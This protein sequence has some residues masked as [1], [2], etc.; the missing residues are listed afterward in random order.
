MDKNLTV[1][2]LGDDG[3]AKVFHT[4]YKLSGLLGM[5]ISDRSFYTFNWEEKEE[6]SSTNIS[7]SEGNEQIVEANKSRTGKDELGVVHVEYFK[8]MWGSDEKIRF[9]KVKQAHAG[10]KLPRGEKEKTKDILK[11]TRRDV[12]NLIEFIAHKIK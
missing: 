2:E 3:G 11:H 1:T 8:I 10:G 9:L 6:T 4:H 12:E 7:T 5:L